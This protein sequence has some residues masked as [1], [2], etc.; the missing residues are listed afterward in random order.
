VSNLESSFPT[1]QQFLEYRA[2]IVQAIA[3][4]WHDDAFRVK[5]VDDPQ[6]AL[7]D[8]FG[9]R[10]PFSLALDT[11]EWT[12]AT[13]GGWTT[14]ENNVLELVLPPAPAD[15]EQH[16]IALAAYNAKHISVIEDAKQ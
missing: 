5:L 1:Y 9:Y 6:K 2:V 10:Y 11:S 14:L 15:P 3:V 12:P 16:A 8:R 13:N 7:A 4:A